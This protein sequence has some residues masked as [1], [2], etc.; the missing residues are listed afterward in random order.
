[1]NAKQ[2]TITALNN[3][4]PDCVPVTL[5]LSE[6]VP[7]RKSGLSCINYFWDE[8]RDLVRDR[9]DV[10]KSFGADVFLHSG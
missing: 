9:C 4:L 3:G 1:M 10:E 8:K 7:V 5:G 6:M 2:R